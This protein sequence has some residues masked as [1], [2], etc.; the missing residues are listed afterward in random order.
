MYIRQ[1]INAQNL[2]PLNKYGTTRRARNSGVQSGET[3]FKGTYTSVTVPMY[4]WCPALTGSF[5]RP[6]RRMSFFQYARH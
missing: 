4:E 1:D 2:R 6:K 5:K 3:S